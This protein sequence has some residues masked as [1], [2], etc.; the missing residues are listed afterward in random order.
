MTSVMTGLSTSVDGF[1]AGPEDGVGQP[2]GVG[3]DRLFDWFT[4]GDTQSR[5]YPT[6]KMSAAVFA[7]GAVAWAVSESHEP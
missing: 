2:L 5:H 1:I 3:G 7:I 4:D 6:F